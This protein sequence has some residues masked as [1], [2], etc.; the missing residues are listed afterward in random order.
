MT[1]GSECHSF[2]LSG[3]HFSVDEVNELA[4]DHEEA[5]T[6]LLLHSKYAAT[7][8]ENVVIK[9]PDTDVFIIAIA[10]CT[11]VSDESNIYFETGQKVK[12]IIHVNKVAEKLGP[13][14]ASAL[15]GLHAF[16]GCDSVSS[17]YGRGKV[18]AWKVMEEEKSGDTFI[19]LGREITLERSYVAAG[20]FSMCSVLAE[21]MYL[22]KRS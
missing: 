3:G 9:S 2:S 19:A 17:F 4:C 7:R 5:D 1:H 10:L 14:N 22:C 13:H 8:S 18:K 12:R 6:R 16:M 11:D 21:R 20:V 15:L